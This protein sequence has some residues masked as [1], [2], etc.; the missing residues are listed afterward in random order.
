MMLGF[1][2]IAPITRKGVKDPAFNHDLALGELCRVSWLQ[3]FSR[4]IE[5]FETFGF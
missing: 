1:E 3:C 4:K 2:P 5:T